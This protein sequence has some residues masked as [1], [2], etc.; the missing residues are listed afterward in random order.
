MIPAEDEGEAEEVMSELGF[1]DDA[2]RP[3]DVNALLAPQ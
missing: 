2:L 1:E 3:F